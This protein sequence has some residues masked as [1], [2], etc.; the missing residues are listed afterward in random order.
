MQILPTPNVTW[1][2]TH[3]ANM[4][5]VSGSGG[6]GVGGKGVQNDDDEGV[7]ELQT[8]LVKFK[9]KKSSQKKSSKKG[10]S[11][12]SESGK[13]KDDEGKKLLSFG[14]D[15]TE[16][17]MKEASLLFCLER[18]DKKVMQDFRLK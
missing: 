8:R 9:E 5:C 11:L 6:E 3:T 2:K 14:E 13:S 18:Y 16:G 15:L 17:G 12:K 4:H 10:S 7:D 1:Q